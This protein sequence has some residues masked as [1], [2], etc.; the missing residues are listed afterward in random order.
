MGFADAQLAWLWGTGEDDVRARRLAAGV[1]A[2]FKTVDTCGAEFEA[3]TPYHYSTYEDE[4]ETVAA[5]RP[6]V[7]ILGSGPNRIGQGIEFDYC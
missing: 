2:T 6:T 3:M 4:D 5:T 1:R 7:I